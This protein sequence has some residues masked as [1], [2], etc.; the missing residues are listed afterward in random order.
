M[1]MHISYSYWIAAGIFWAMGLGRTF[2]LLTAAVTAH[3]M[4]HVL[5]AKLFGC[6]L[7]RWHISAMGEMAEIDGLNELPPL[8]RIM[9]IAAGPACN[10]ILFQIFGGQFGF[11]NI[12]LFGFNLL[13]IFPLDGARLYQILLGNWKGI[14][15]ANRWIL[16][17]GEACCVILMALGLV[18]AYYF[19]PNFTMLIVGLVLWRRNRSLEIELTGEFYMAMLN[20]STK[21]DGQSPLPIKI[22]QSYHNQPI[23]EIIDSMGWDHELKIILPDRSIVTEQEVLK[24]AIR[25]G[26]KGVTIS[27]YLKE[28]Y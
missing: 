16:K 18:Q 25:H 1:K 3:E 22:I 13:P 9:I 27:P 6:R 21:R 19:A 26:I 7:K 4:S 11:Y 17:A 23:S 24:Y 5:I 10:L 28:T 20:K 12:I 15:R 2:L 14:K 8:K